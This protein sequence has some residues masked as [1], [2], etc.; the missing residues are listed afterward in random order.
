MIPAAL[1][2]LA[3][4]GQAQANLTTCERQC[5]CERAGRAGE[6]GDSWACTSMGCECADTTITMK[7][8]C[9]YAELLAAARAVEP[10]LRP[11]PC[12]G[13]LAF[14][15]GV[16]RTPP[17]EQERLRA[18]ADRLDREDAAIARFRAALKNCGE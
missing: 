5:E 4:H 8:P 1:V 11:A 14:N 16:Y 2:M 13:C 10:F 18:E 15:D 12:P 9:D 17:T 7:S 3:L 6:L